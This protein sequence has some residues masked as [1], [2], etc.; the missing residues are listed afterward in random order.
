MIY[1]LD[2]NYST[3]FYNEIIETLNRKNIPYSEY[4]DTKL[5]NF[6]I[7]T[8]DEPGFL[9]YK[10]LDTSTGRFIVSKTKSVDINDEF[11]LL[12]REAY[13]SKNALD[14][15]AMNDA[16]KYCKQNGSFNFFHGSHSLASDLS[17]KVGRVYYLG[18]HYRYYIYLTHNSYVSNFVNPSQFL[19]YDTDAFQAEMRL[20]YEVFKY[21]DRLEKYSKTP[22]F[23]DGKIHYPTK[24]ANKFKIYR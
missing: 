1:T 13:S 9:E 22:Y 16:F 7:E 8:D 19:L 17:K 23:E 5:Y 15:Y 4:I 20:N 12:R 24:T 6:Y 14:R 3:Q 10:S 18:K 2:Y 11:Y 21:F